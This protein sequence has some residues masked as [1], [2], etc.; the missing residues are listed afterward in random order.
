VT[1]GAYQSLYNAIYGHIDHGDEAII[2][3]PF[4]GK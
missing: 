2:I 4:Y 3:E 1:V